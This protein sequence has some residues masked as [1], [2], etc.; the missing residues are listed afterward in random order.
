MRSVLIHQLQDN[1]CITCM[2]HY[3]SIYCKNTRR[4]NYGKKRKVINKASTLY[5]QAYIN[6]ELERTKMSLYVTATFCFDYFIL[7][8]LFSQKLY[9]EHY[10]EAFLKENMQK[11]KHTIELFKSEQ[12]GM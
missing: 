1:E 8:K 5:N 6:I 12:N 10:L 4:K 3:Q 2:V 7:K 9:L 11:S